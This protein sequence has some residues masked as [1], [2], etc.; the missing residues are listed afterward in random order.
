MLA[1]A[2]AT[3]EEARSALAFLNHFQAPGEGHWVRASLGNRE[4]LVLVT[5][6][7]VINAALGLGR[8]L[9]AE[10]V[11]GVC[12]LGIA[13]SF[14]PGLPVG[15]V[16][17]ATAECWPEYGVAGDSGVDAAALGRPLLDEG[18]VT[19]RLDLDPEASAQA[20]GLHL[21]TDWARGPGLTVSAV[22][23]T[24]GRTAELQERHGALTE[25]MEGF[26]LALGCRR[27]GLPFLEVRTV[28]NLVGPG[29]ESWDIRTALAALGRTAARLLGAPEKAA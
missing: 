3:T 20:M 27:A 6:L 5:G 1:L 15:A 26:A 10:P 4:M 13:G 14:D 23:A 29:R 2:F 21:S 9:A 18:N 8:L 22:T 25:S 17:V 19:D 12:N 28:S 24:A 16:A 11:T 7:S